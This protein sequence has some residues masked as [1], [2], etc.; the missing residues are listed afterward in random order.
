MQKFFAI[1]F[2]IVVDNIIKICNHAKTIAE[3]PRKKQQQKRQKKMIKNIL[4]KLLTPAPKMA[5]EIVRNDRGGYSIAITI[6]AKKTR[7]GNYPTR[8]DALRVC[9]MNGY[10]NQ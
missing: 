7:V 3:K 6:G 1:F 10:N 4:K 2:E 5:A 9:T 8:A